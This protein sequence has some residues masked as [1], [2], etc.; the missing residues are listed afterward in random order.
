MKLSHV[1][2]LII[3]SSILS[4]GFVIDISLA[5]SEFDRE[6]PYEAYVY[7]YRFGGNEN[8]LHVYMYARA[9][10]T[11]RARNGFLSIY[12]S[13]SN[14]W[15]DPRNTPASV[16]RHTWFYDDYTF[17]NEENKGYISATAYGSC[18]GGGSQI[19]FA[20][21]DVDPM[22]P[23]K[24]QE[25]TTTEPEAGISATDSDDTVTTGETHEYKLIT[26]TPYYWVDWYVKTPWDTSESKRGT[27]ITYEYGDG[28][29]TESTFSYNFPSGS[30]HTGDFLIT[31]V[32]WRWSDMFEYEETYTET[33][34]LE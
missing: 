31:A 9:S 21:L 16:N 19:A 32:I 14:G 3:F 20:N 13:L 11:D 25:G 8:R 4:V 1:L 23:P 34:T 26:E 17:Q 27:Y 7:W 12:F 2:L 30:M 29:K 6:M 24:P 15:S 28:T 5:E 22:P 18:T 33:V 10:C